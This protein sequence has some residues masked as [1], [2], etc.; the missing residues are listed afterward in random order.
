MRYGLPA[1][2]MSLFCAFPALALD[3]PARKAGLWELKLTH[4]S[5]QAPPQVMQHCIDAAT[6]KAMNE[7]FSGGQ[8]MCSK[9]DIRKSGTTIVAE[10][11][12]KTGDMAMTTRAVFDGDFNSAYT[13]KISTEMEGS[14][15]RPPVGG[16]T[17]MTMEAK[18]L[19]PCKAGQKPGDVEMS[20]GMKMNILDLPKTPTPPQR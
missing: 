16:K 6:D 13:V 10:S 20:N 1:I 9:Q 19:G 3:L 17:N 2:A 11:S 8:G 5:G 7:K 12:C 15:A 18:W 4:E 14:A